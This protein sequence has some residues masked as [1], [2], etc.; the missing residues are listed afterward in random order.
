MG[1]GFE[2]VVLLMGGVFLG[3][4]IDK[5]MGWAGYST[6]VLILSLLASWFYHLLF[7]LKKMEDMDDSDPPKGHQ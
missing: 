6:I 7:L 5:Y 1:M 2:L 3:Q 4:Q